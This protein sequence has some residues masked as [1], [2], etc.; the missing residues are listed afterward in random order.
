MVQV[1]LQAH[2]RK[3]TDAVLM[4]VRS[5]SQIVFRAGLQNQFWVLLMRTGEKEER[6]LSS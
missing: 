4:S 3:L 1:Q 5:W 2:F 6:E